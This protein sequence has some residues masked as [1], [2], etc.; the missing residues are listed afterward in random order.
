MALRNER[1]AQGCAAL[2]KLLFLGLFLALL[3]FLGGRTVIAFFIFVICSFLG[4]LLARSANAFQNNDFLRL[5]GDVELRVN[6]DSTFQQSW[7]VSLPL[8]GAA[9]GK[10]T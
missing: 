1:A 7:N 9:E 10:G 3:L 2:V 8:E 6:V 4:G 5:K